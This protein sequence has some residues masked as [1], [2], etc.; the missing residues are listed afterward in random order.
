MVVSILTLASFVKVFHSVFMGPRLPEHGPVSEVPRAMLFGMG[1]LAVVVLAFGFVPA[2]AVE[3]IV[4][5]A[6]E[7]LLDRAGY[8]AAVLGGG[9]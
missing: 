8:I 6:A 9:N 4:G 1:L 7:A 3:N 2:A 5:P